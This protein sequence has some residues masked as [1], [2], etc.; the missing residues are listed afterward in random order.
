MSTVTDLTQPSTWAERIEK[1]DV[2][3]KLNLIH[4]EVTA[5]FKTAP[6]ML[7]NGTL[8]KEEVERMLTAASA[9]PMDTMVTISPINKTI[10]IL[11]HTTKLGGDLLN[12]KVAYFSLVLTGTSAVPVVFDPESILSTVEITPPTWT[13]LKE[14]KTA[15]EIESAPQGRT[16]TTITGSLPIPPFLAAAFIDLE[17]PSPAKAFLKAKEVA[18]ALEEDTGNPTGEEPITTTLKIVLPYLWA[19]HKGLIPT[20]G[21]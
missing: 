9:L 16:K 11:S 15:A 13:T 4:H 21:K 14:V 6:D 20:V 1:S 7:E 18:D 2:S 10:E 3:P 8:K 19:T 17:D 12:K 5:L